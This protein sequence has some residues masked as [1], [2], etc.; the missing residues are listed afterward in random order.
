MAKENEI[1]ALWKPNTDS[2]R[3]PL[4][5]GSITIGGVT[6]RIVV[7]P[8]RFKKPGEKSPDFRIEVEQP[9]QAPAPRVAAPADD[10]PDDIPHF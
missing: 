2:D 3:A 8:N 6:T 1:G 9:R 5:S 4:A 10:F 7:W